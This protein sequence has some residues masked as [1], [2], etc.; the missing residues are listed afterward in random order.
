VRLSPDALAIWVSS[1]TPANAAHGTSHL[2]ARCAI[3]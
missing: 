2:P 3:T 1:I